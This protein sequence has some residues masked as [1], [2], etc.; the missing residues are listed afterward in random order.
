MSRH[1]AVD[2]SSIGPAPAAEENT[3]NE[4]S[5]LAEPLL[6]HSAVRRYRTGEADPAAPR[7]AAPH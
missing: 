6:I 5:F 7:R 2:E 4:I 3:P 1:S